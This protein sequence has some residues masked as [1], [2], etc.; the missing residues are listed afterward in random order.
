MS[1]HDELV[2]IDDGIKSLQST[3]LGKQFQE[4]SGRWVELDLSCSSLQSIGLQGSLD[5][6]VDE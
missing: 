6:W 1:G 2:G 5:G 3:V 4:E